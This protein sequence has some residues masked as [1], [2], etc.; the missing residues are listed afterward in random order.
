MRGGGEL[1]V[2]IAGLAFGGAERIVLDWALRIQPAWNVH[3]I[4][5]REH[6]N[7][8]TVPSPVRV[9]RLGGADVLAKLT[10]LGRRLA[11]SRVP[12]C[13]CHLLTAA[14]RDALAI[15]GAFIV[16]VL[17]NARAGW[18]EDASALHGARLVIAVSGAAAADVRGEGCDAAV[19]VIRHIPRPRRFAHDARAAW[20]RTW[21]I[22]EDATVAGMI[23]AVKPQKDY[24]F[25]IRLLRRLLAD[26]DLY[27]VIVGGPA[28]RHG[29]DAW[30]AVLEEMRAA[31]V[32]HRLAMPGFHPDA[33]ACLPA[34]DLLLNTSVYE[35]TSI[36][37]L[38]ALMKGVPVVASWVGGQGEL[39]AD[40]LTLV[41]KDAPLD[42][43][44]G[45]VATALHQSPPFPAWTGFPS[46]RLW[47]LAHL[48]RP[49]RR[50]DRVLFVTANLNAGGAQRSLVNLATA[51]RNVRFE[52]AVTGD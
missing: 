1:T 2:A 18:L 46:Y 33:A 40:G 16:P 47:T 5:L 31:G 42:A 28:G 4:V 38:E 35:G 10:H 37:T 52:I 29:R 25:A 17:H 32:R 26:R 22:P 23:G 20:R 12:V 50:D 14:E 41:D 11:E 13:V 7:E 51:L 8:W 3:L 24:P 19:S 39:A 9:T 48:A 6:P 15:G 49:F 34:F 27:L 21:R 36:A 44:A 30:H 45:A 43:W